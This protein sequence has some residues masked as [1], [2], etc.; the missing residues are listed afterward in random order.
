MMWQ[1]TLLLFLET[2]PC[3][4]CTR[5]RYHFRVTV[6]KVK[7]KQLVP[8]GLITRLLQIKRAQQQQQHRQGV[9]SKRI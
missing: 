5:M 6:V 9:I 7:L 2:L 3:Q 1:P 8:H 4:G